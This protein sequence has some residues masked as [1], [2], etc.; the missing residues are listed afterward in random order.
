[1]NIDQLFE[2]L[3]GQFEAA[4]EQGLPKP[5]LGIERLT[6][7]IS[8][9]RLSLDRPTLGDTYIC[10]LVSGRAIWRF[11]PHRTLSAARITFSKEPSAQIDGPNAHQLLSESLLQRFVRYSL[12]GDGQQIRRGRVKAIMH[13]LILFESSAEVIAVA[14][15]RLAWLE[16]HASEN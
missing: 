4:L 2:E 1:M 9:T 11:Q 13:G 14:I 7:T 3:E 12:A 15:E 5:N 16:V 6:T 10:G 8:G